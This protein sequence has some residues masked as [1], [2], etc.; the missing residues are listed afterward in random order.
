[1]PEQLN[2]EQLDSLS[3]ALKYFLKEANLPT[4]FEF[5]MEFST[6][7]L[8]DTSD[9]PEYQR[10]CSQLAFRLYDLFSRQGKDIPEILNQWREFSESSV[11][12]EVKKVWKT[13]PESPL[14]QQ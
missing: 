4:L 13:L 2:D 5:E 7:S 10:I 1:M 8:I 14:I 11:L 3:L 12:P 9:R 6:K